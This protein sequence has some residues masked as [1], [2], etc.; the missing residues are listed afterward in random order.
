MRDIGA[1]R[2]RPGLRRRFPANRCATRPTTAPL[3][4]LFNWYKLKRRPFIRVLFQ[5]SR[6]NFADV[7]SDLIGTIYNTYVEW[8]EK[9]QQGQYRTPLSPDHPN[10]ALFTRLNPLLIP[11]QTVYENCIV[12]LYSRRLEYTIC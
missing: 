11:L 1:A 9:R 6:F 4:E 12:G 7:D 2:L 10:Y 3:R 8:E 5:L